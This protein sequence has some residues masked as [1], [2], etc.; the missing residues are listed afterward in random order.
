M[1]DIGMLAAMLGMFE[2]QISL[3]PNAAFE[4]EDGELVLVVQ[5]DADNIRF[6]RSQNR[7]SADPFK[8]SGYVR[9][10]LALQKLVQNGWFEVS[11]TGAG[12]RIRLGER[13]K[14]EG[15]EPKR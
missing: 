14:A 10:R 3:F 6:S 2:N 5:G 4:E 1:A 7:Q 15:K 9:E 11:N 12:L 13:A 8:S